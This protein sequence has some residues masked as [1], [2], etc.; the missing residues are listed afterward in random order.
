MLKLQKRIF[1]EVKELR[2]EKKK[3]NLDV[4]LLD[5]KNEGLQE[6]IIE[7]QKRGYTPD[8]L[9]KIRGVEHIH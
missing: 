5:E 1:K 7:L 3:L 8:V 9:K 4:E 6:E 2:E